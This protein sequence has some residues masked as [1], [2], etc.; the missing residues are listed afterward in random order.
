MDLG[1]AFAAE[2]GTMKVNEE[3]DALSTM[4]LDPVGFLVIPRMIAAIAMT[5]LLTIF[6][7]CIG[8]AGGAVV[9]LH[10]G[11]P[12]VSYFHQVVSAVNYIDLCGGLIKSVVFGLLVAGLGCYRGLQTAVGASAVGDSAT[13]SVVSSIIFIVAVDGLFSIIYYSLGV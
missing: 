8:V 2:L 5:P 1:S 7:D 10:L 6:A 3:I 13:R 9:M 11:Y 4:G 12:P